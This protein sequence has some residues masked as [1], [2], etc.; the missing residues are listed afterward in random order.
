VALVRNATAQMADVPLMFFLTAAIA[1]LALQESA[2][3]EERAPLVALA[4]VAAAL[5]AWTKNEGALFV[6]VFALAHG[7]TAAR[8]NGWRAAGR[9]VVPLAAGALPVVLLLLYFKLALAPSGAA[10]LWQQGP[11]LLGRLTDPARHALIVREFATRTLLYRGPGID[12][13]YVLLLYAIFAF[14][15][16]ARHA[17]WLHGALTLVLL[18]AGYFV[19]YLTT[20]YDLGWHVVTSMDRL[21]LQTWPALVLVVMLRGPS[22]DALSRALRRAPRSAPA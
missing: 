4:G 12:V 19:V 6:I 20:P 13:G 16:R 15:T 7:V 8:K 22:G 14:M 2:P 10:S 5:A 3:E 18:W 9:T 17:T 1:L 21:L 11:S